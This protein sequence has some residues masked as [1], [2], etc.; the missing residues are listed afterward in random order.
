MNNYG[1][2][3]TLIGETTELRNQSPPKSLTTEE[4]RVWLTSKFAEVLGVDPREIDSS[5]PLTNYGLGSI[6]ALTLVA[7]LEEWMDRTLPA[8]LLW[9]CSTLDEIID[10]VSESPAA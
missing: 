4:I 9:D 3:E 8:T 5:E 2:I 10:Y 6:Q 1:S 7:E